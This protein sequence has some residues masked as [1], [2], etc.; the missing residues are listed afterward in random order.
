MRQRLGIAL[1]INI[2]L[3]YYRIIE[4]GL[5]VMDVQVPIAQ[6]SPSVPHDWPKY[7]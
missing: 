6:A 5:R 4:F 2:R 1:L 7:A 3:C